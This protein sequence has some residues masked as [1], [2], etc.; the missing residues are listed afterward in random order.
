MLKRLKLKKYPMAK[1]IFPLLAYF[2]QHKQYF[3]TKK[4]TAKSPKSATNGDADC[5]SGGR[6]EKT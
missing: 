5:P 1:L 6:D 4:H 2:A 3:P